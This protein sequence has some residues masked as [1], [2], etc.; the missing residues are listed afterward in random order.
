MVM[1]RSGH[2]HKNESPN[3]RGPVRLE[4][5][6]FFAPTALHMIRKERLPFDGEFSL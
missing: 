2:S 6:R 1:A 4:G 5:E 3:C